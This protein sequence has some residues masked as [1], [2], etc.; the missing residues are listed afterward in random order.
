M[1]SPSI[2]AFIDVLLRVRVHS[3]DEARIGASQKLLF[4]NLLSNLLRRSRSHCVHV[5]DLV[6][7]DLRQMPD[8]V[9]EM[10][11]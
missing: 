8:E 6:F 9:N 4:F 1:T 3:V 7:G 5:L 11:C 10:P 2:K